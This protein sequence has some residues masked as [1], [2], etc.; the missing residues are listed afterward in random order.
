MGF[1]YSAFEQITNHAARMRNRTRGRLT[2]PIVFRA[3][4]GGGI[5]APEHHSESDEAIFTHIPGL[6]V[7]IPSSPLSAYGLLLAAINDP[8]PVLFL[9][10]K[11]IYRAIKQSVPN[12]GNALPLD[13]AY[14]LKN[15]NDITLISWGAMLQETLIAAEELEKKD[16]SAEVIDLATIKPIDTNTL[17]DSVATTGRAVIVHEAHKTGGVGAEIVALL[18]EYAFE[19]LKAPILRVT[20]FDIVMPYFKMETYYL[21][22]V[23][24]ILD[25]VYNTLEYA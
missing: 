7:V 17:L 13:K 14:V 20:G 19:D 18:N 24:R 21:P 5:R 11:R 4:Y 10:P 2:C 1:I 22:S 23:K 15:G 9:E 12:N 16:I 8:D 6:R 3:P 25:A